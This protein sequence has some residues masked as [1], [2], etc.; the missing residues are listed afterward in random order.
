MT[1]TVSASFHDQSYPGTYSEKMKQAAIA[2]T[3]AYAQA[4]KD[5][6]FVVGSLT[7]AGAVTY[8][9]DKATERTE[10]AE[11]TDSAKDGSE[12]EGDGEGEE[13]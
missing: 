11:R 3:E 13:E 2:A 1:V 4:L 9:F 10:S 7:L 8:N 12:S 6:G 5:A